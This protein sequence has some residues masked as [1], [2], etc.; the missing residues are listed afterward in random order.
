VDANRQRFVD[1]ILKL[2][3]VAASTS[4]TAEADTARALAAE[5]MAKHNIDA[6]NAPKDRAVM[7]TQ[8]YTPFKPDMMW[9]FILVQAI[10]RLCGCAMFWKGDQEH[11]K[12]FSVVGLVPDVEAAF[13]ILAKINQQRMRKWLEYKQYG[14]DNFGKFCF[15]FARGVEG[16]VEDILRSA[17][18]IAKNVAV[19]ALWYRSQHNVTEE[20]ISFGRASSSAGLSAGESARFYRGEMSAPPKRLR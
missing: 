12:T 9:E 13:Y 18:A 4:F 16:K 20:S 17:P 14:P 7:A 19:A 6:V 1:R 15:G 11:F 5:L 3:A 2:L 8:I 10:T